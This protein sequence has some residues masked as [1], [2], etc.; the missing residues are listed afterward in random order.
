M[1]RRDRKRVVKGRGRSYAKAFVHDDASI[2][3]AASGGFTPS[4]AARFGRALLEFAAVAERMSTE[5]NEKQ[6]GAT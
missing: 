1:G 2:S 6:E 3:I 4:Q 5:P